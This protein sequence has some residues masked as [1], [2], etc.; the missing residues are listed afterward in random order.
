MLNKVI[1]MGRLC[2]DPEVRQTTTGIPVCRYRI[3]VN[4][5]Y[6][7]DQEQQADFIT[8]I[9]WRTTA[10]FIARYFTKGKMILVEG[11]LRNNNYTD[12][13]GTKHYTMEVMTETVGF[14]E[15]KRADDGNAESPQSSE[16]YADL[17]RDAAPMY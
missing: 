5:P 2:A 9:A 12:G 8:C 6:R 1:M 11:K 14:G 4:R 15:P 13:N 16:E 7:K 3:A 10:E 17:F